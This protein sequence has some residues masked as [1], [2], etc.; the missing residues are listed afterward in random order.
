MACYIYFVTNQIMISIR[1]FIRIVHNSD[2]ILEN[3][4]FLEDP[5]YFID[6]D[7]PMPI[8]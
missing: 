8:S 3:A 6:N 1:S 4:H 7:G 5:A 2:H